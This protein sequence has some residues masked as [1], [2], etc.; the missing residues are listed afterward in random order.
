[1]H[2]RPHALLLLPLSITATLADFLGPTH[3]PP[4]DLSSDKS[5]V[6]ASWKN[7]TSV[8]DAYLKGNHNSSNGTSSEALSGVEKVTFSAGLFSI[9]DPAAAKLQYHY[10]SPE[11]ANATQGTTQVDGDSIY[12]TASVSKLFTAFA[13]LLELTNDEWHRPLTD[14]IPGLADFASARSANGTAAAGED[15]P[16]YRIQWDRITPWALAAQ[17]AGVPTLGL[18]D[19][20]YAYI[21]QTRSGL[22]A[23]NP[24]TEY[25]LPP[26]NISD[27]G[28]CYDAM[29]PEVTFCPADEFILSERSLPPTFLPWTTP[30]YSDDGFMLLGIAISNIT[31]KSMASIYRQSIF[32]PL[33][34]TSSNSS[35]ASN[36]AELARSVIAGDFASYTIDSGFTTPS[37]GIF[38]TI[39]DLAKFGV[40]I[41]NST[42]FPTKPE[43]TRKWMKPL[44]HTASLSYSVGAPWEIIRYIHPSTGKVTDLYTKLGDSVTYGGALVLIPDYN[45]G[46]SLLDTSSDGALRGVV[47]NL[48]LDYLTENILP[49][50]EAQAAAEA[51]ANYVGEYVS[52]D[53]K[54]NSSVSVVYLNVGEPSTTGPGL[55]ISSWISNGTDVLASLYQGVKPRLLPSIITIPPLA[56]ADKYNNNNNNNNKTGNVRKVAFQAS[57]HLQ[58]N[59]Y[60]VG[61][62]PFTAL[63]A[64]NFDW[65]VVDQVHY[66]GLGLQ[67]FVFDLDEGGFATTLS[68]AATRVKLQ[69]KKILI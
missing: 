17:Q 47:G 14:I 51:A 21:S 52:T 59:S 27:L 26:V 48:I 24:A 49:A 37:G 25:G 33:G 53:A 36:K 38:S 11:I 6:A 13:G 45:A 16:V 50:L 29:N 40:A 3:P 65:L 23:T 35:V 61:S 20:L 39:N 32:E 2:L 15:G 57:T 31:G 8:V 44:S 55:A 42:L 34:M 64:T 22:N 19:L 63:Y 12:R 5:L 68:S 4:I 43:L 56:A 66:G 62:G 28:P 58:T 10:T 60:T 41:L 54:L 1:M 9:H 30:A 69:R 46:F 7:L 18:I 67:L